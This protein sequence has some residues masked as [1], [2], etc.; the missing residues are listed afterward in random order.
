MAPINSL[1]LP[2]ILSRVAS[3]L[4]SDEQARCLRVCKFWLETIEPLV[5]KELTIDQDNLQLCPTPDI[6]Q[7]HR[8]QIALLRIEGLSVSRSYI[9]EFPKLHTMTISLDYS[10]EEDEHDKNLDLESN[11][12]YLI[13][14]NPSIVCLKIIELRMYITGSFW[15]SVSQLPQLKSISLHTGI[16]YGEDTI[17]AFWKACA[18][19]ESLE[20][21]A[22][23]LEKEDA[24]VVDC[25]STVST[26]S[27]T[28]PRLRR[29]QLFGLEGWDEMCQLDLFSQCPKLECL[30]WDQKATASARSPHWISGQLVKRIASRTWPHL[31]SVSL[32][33]EGAILQDSNI[34]MILDGIDQATRVCFPGGSGFG[35]LAF[36]ALRRHFSH[37]Q[38]L[39]LLDGRDVESWMLQEI[40]SSCPA[41]T[42]LRAP[43]LLAK[44]VVEGSPWVCL[45][46]RALIVGFV[47]KSGEENL[48]PQVFE[49]LSRLSSLEALHVGKVASGRLQ[50]SLDFRLECGL[51][52]LASLKRLTHLFLHGTRQS[53]GP[54]DIAWMV[55][56]WS[57]LR[58]IHGTLNTVPGE[59]IRLRRLLRSLTDGR[60]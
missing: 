40:L 46:M 52:A 39:D 59:N 31:R 10:P 29:L 23:K 7:L 42:A 57:C 15:S 20:L 35:P 45:K 58:S 37:L 18:S 17:D 48:Q 22:I 26:M 25:S 16:M 34:S 6:L 36:R 19:L 43:S 28:F 53:I 24:V 56:N 11:A 60:R 14:S 9:M 3:F 47:F 50:G 5:W 32:R 27:T 30:T 12:M 54:L 33:Q 2:E 13:Q 8:H 21:V 38:E 1:D 41:L 4:S 55:T 51:M 44:D 49:R